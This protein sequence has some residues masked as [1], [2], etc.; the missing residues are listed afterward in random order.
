VVK[1]AP[2]PTWVRLEDRPLPKD[3]PVEKVVPRWGLGALAGTDLLGFGDYEPLRFSYLTW[4]YTR[5]KSHL[6]PPMER[7]WKQN[8]Y[9]M[10]LWTETG[11]SGDRV[12]P[13]KNLVDFMLF[14]GVP[15]AREHIVPNF[16][17]SYEGFNAE[18]AALVVDDTPERLRWVGYNF[19]AQPQ[20]GRLRVWR[21]VPGTYEVRMGPDENDDDRIDGDDAAALRV[22]LKRVEAIPVSLPVRKSFVVEAKLVERDV[23]LHDRCDLAITHLDAAREGGRLTVVAHNLGRVATGA[24]QAVLKDAQGRELGRRQHAG[25]E[26][27]EDLQDKRAAISFEQVPPGPV[28]VELTGQKKEITEANNVARIP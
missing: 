11:Q 28:V 17:V 14:G 20:S 26:G 21:L 12:A 7:I 4:H 27:I 2:D 1:A 5:D 18:L 15:S 3:T 10:P 9:A 6:V 24:F 19:D 23:P 16:A 22:E 8:Y 13:H 25:V